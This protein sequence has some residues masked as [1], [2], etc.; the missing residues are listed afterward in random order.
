MANNGDIP[1]V[2]KSTQKTTITALA[3]V[4][5]FLV[6]ALI[7]SLTFGVVQ[8]TKKEKVPEPIFYEVSKIENK[9]VRVQRGNLSADKLSLLRDLSMRTYVT[10][11][12]TINH[13]DDKGRWEKIRLSSS[14]DV[15]KDF[16]NLMNPEVNKDSIFSNK[17]FTR[18]VIVT[19]DYPIGSSVGGARIPI[20]RVEFDVIDTVS[21]EELPPQSF[22][23]II[24]YQILDDYSAKHKDRHDNI[25]GLRVTSYQITTPQAY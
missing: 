7:G 8:F 21:G 22:T 2:V 10:M 13:S 16:F 6:L 12:E 20:H 19:D 24:R 5:V 25:L 14:N 3:V 1:F 17:D 15:Y 9:I 23:A 18:K 4:C 11:R